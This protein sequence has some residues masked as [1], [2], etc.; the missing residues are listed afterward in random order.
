MKQNWMI[1]NQITNWE[2]NDFAQ[3]NNLMIYDF[4]NPDHKQEI[5]Y[6]RFTKDTHF[7]LLCYK[8]E[9]YILLL[10]YF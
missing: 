6:E 2:K 1:F 8:I 9:W 3:N 10:Y 5:K 4:F 7:D